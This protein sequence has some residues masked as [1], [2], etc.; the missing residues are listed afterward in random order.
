MIDN[1]WIDHLHHLDHLRDGIGLRAYGQKDPLIEYKT[2]AYQLFQG[3]TCH[4]QENFVRVLFN[5]R[6]EIQLQPQAMS[7]VAETPE[8]S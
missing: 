1:L 2:E 5:T 3:L 7:P 4:I 8:L 6:V